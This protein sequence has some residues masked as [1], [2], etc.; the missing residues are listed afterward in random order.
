ML[1]KIESKRRNGHE[2]EQAPENGK[3]QESFVWGKSMGSQGVGGY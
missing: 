3:E 2:F 1:G